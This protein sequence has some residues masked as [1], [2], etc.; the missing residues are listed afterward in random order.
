MKQ[1]TRKEMREIM[2]VRGYSQKT[3]EHYIFHVRNLAAYF[4]KPPHTLTPEHI[5]KYQ[6]FLVH[7]KQ[8]SWSSFNIAVCAIRFFLTS[9]WAM[10]GLSN[11]SL[12]KK[13]TRLFRS[14]STEK[15]L[16]HSF[17]SSKIQNIMP[18]LQHSTVRGSGFQNASI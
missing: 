5:H 17:L 13:N 8:F 6:V 10:T 2:E 16:R 7:E 4:N 11:T 12:I 3:I 1:Y 15:K 14:C 9:W 18:S